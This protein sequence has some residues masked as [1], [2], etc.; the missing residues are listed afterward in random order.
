MILKKIMGQHYHEGSARIIAWDDTVQE[1]EGLPQKWAVLAKATG[2]VPQVEVY[3][4]F[5]CHQRSLISDT[6]LCEDWW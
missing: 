6:I 2:G 5:Y 1:M 3:G 4:N